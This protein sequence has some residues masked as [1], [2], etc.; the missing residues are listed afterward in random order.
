MVAMKSSNRK[1]N[2]LRAPTI[3][4]LKKIYCFCPKFQK[5]TFL[6]PFYIKCTDLA[7]NYY[8]KLYRKCNYFRDIVNLKLFLVNT[9]CREPLGRPNRYW[10][11]S[12]GNKSR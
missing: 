4:A 3:G 2:S 1:P 10:Y 8:T 11:R 9:T 7:K 5:K 12:L 6:I